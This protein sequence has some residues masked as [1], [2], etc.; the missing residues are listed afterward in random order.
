MQTLVK[1]G[2]LLSIAALEKS[3]DVWKPYIFDLKKAQ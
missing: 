1:H 3:D 2:H